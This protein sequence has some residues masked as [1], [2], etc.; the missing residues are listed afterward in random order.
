MSR[1]RDERRLYRDLAW[2]WPILSPPERYVR[3][4][5]EIRRL[6][7]RRVPGA[8]TLLHL[9]CG[10]GHLDRTLKR[11]FEITGIDASPSMLALA[12]GLNPKVAY[13]VGDMRSV[14]LGRRFDA[15]LIADSVA[16]MQTEKEL[17]AAF[18]TAW[19]H[20]APGGVFVTYVE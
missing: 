14:R 6:I 19:V 2:T 7:R 15:V 18:R 12:R 20:L 1:S 16:Y 5:R 10:G 4:A 13:R 3:E 9:G 11:S 8:S 17:R